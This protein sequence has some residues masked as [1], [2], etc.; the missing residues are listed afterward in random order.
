MSYFNL[1]SCRSIP[2]AISDGSGR[3]LA[4]R[5]LRKTYRINRRRPSIQAT[6]NITTFR[7]ITEAPAISL[8]TRRF[9]A[10]SI[11]QVLRH[12]S[13]IANFHSLINLPITGIRQF[14]IVNVRIQIRFFRDS[15]VQ[16]PIMV[17]ILLLLSFL[18][19][20]GESTNSKA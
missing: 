17:I 6:S 11:V 10:I 8:E 1:P 9:N 3:D 20:V 16:A 4:I 13:L 5:I 2:F 7:L 12:P 14:A 15:P 19:P 18:H